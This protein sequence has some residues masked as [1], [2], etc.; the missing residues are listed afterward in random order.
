MVAHLS[1]PVKLDTLQ[2]LLHKYAA[3]AAPPERPPPP[4][5]SPQPQQVTRVSAWG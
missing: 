4:P 1:K 5:P 2:A 3:A